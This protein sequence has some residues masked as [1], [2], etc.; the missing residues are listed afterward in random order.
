MRARVLVV[1]VLVTAAATVFDWRSR[2]QGPPP[3][4]ARKSGS[5]EWLAD[6]HARTIAA[7]TAAFLVEMVVEVDGHDPVV[8]RESGAFDA[9][10]RR[11]WHS[12][13]VANGEETSQ[14][15]RV[16]VVDDDAWISPGHVAAN[17]GLEPLQWI[18]S[19]FRTLERFGQHRWR[20]GLPVTGRLVRD[21]V[22]KAVGDAVVVGSEEVRGVPTTHVRPW[23][24][25]PGLPDAAAAGPVDVWVDDR[26]RLRKVQFVADSPERPSQVTLRVELFDYGTPVK[27]TPPEADDVVADDALARQVLARLP[28]GS[29]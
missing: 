10:R 11:R 27:V 26:L 21:L 24:D 8:F 15:I 23:V 16:L 18:G 29:R 3:L 1:L 20:D 7:E 28:R 14:P 5:T 17:L 19:S 25:D 12:V 2:G 13:E 22:L 4:P 9:P 6:A